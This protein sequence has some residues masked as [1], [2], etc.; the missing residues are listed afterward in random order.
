MTLKALDDADGKLIP[1]LAQTLWSWDVCVDCALGRTCISQGCPSSRIFQLQ[2]YIQ[3]YRAI[4][5]T[6]IEGYSGKK[7]LIETCED[8]FVVIS[9]LKSNPDAT[10]AELCQ[11]A[12][13]TTDP[14]SVS[15][16]QIDG[17]ALSVRVIF[18][19]DP[20]ALHHSSH[21]LEIGAFREHWRSDVPFSKFIQDAF[22]IGHHHVLSYANSELFVNVKSE[23]KATHL[24][25]RLGI[26]IRAT[27]DI[28]N[29]LH[30]NRRHN[31][32]EVYH[33][34]GF[35]KEQLR[36]TKD[37]DD[38]SSLS[39]SI[40]R[41]ALPRQLVLEVLDSL[42]GVLFPLADPKSKRLLQSLV[43]SSSFDPDILKFEHSS[44]RRVG[45]ENVS[46]TYFADRL[47]DLYNELQNPR[48][49]GWL[50][51][52]M[53]RKSGARHMMMAT[54]IGV[55]FAVLL[56]IASLAVSSYQAWIAYQA[57]QHPIAPPGQ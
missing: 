31:I 12:F 50:E 14:T 57:W 19:I 17:L 15:A 47:S 56:G 38:C 11:L 46:Y 45:E 29:H 6:Y 39:L 37:L 53:E 28:R 48:P 55:V 26:T 1:R 42:Q 4:I 2:R 10:L 22:P 40:K 49:R 52:E 33:Y 51:Q 13:P 35:L 7:T 27:S 18:M 41:G 16:E 21:I 36:A 5:A 54:L 32:L 8:L 9:A 20:S 24:K 23:L 44:I 34:T 3:Y 30:F 43:S 25:K